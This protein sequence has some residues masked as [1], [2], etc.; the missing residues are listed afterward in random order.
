M[1]KR[2]AFLL[3]HFYVWLSFCDCCILIQLL[4]HNQL[5]LPVWATQAKCKFSACAYVCTLT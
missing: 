1:G 2:I 5:M 4:H 3:P